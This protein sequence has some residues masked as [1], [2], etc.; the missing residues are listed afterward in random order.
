MERLRGA[1]CDVDLV[2]ARTG[3][4]HLLVCTQNQASYDGRVAERRRDQ[5]AVAKLAAE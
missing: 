3:S 2:M 1:G 5:L 4:P